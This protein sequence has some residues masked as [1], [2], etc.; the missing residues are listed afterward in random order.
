MWVLHTLWLDLMSLRSGY[1][2][3]SKNLANNELSA[4]TRFSLN[5]DNVTMNELSTAHV[6]TKNIL[7]FDKTKRNGCQ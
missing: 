1:L 5:E 7:F 4:D 3:T 2:S 6:P